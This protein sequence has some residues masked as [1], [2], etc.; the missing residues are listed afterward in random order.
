MSCNRWLAPE[1]ESPKN[2]TEMPNFSSIIPYAF[3]GRGLN[4]MYDLPNVGNPPKQYGMSL[5][6]NQR[7]TRKQKRQNPHKY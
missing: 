6:K 2:L 7:K 5:R 3:L 4:T 1:N